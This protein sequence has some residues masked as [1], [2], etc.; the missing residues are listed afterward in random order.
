VLFSSSYYGYTRPLVAVEQQA[1]L[2]CIE[3][4]AQ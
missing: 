3:W 1:F 2:G 4:L